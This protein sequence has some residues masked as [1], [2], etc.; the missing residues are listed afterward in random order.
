[1]SRYLVSAPRPDHQG[2]IVGVHFR[3]GTAT[4][5]PAASSVEQAALQYFRRAGY[6]MVAIEE[7]SDTEPAGKARPAT[8]KGAQS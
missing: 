4:V 6:S 1:M 5:D 7:T 8:T 2:Q 3:D